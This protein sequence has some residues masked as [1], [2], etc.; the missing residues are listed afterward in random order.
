MEALKLRGYSP[1]RPVG[2]CLD[3]AASILESVNKHDPL[4]TV[5]RERIR[6]DECTIGR[7]E[8]GD[9]EMVDSWRTVGRVFPA[10]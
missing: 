3:S 6:N 1:E 8:N 9:S 2:I 7:I 5:H 4:V 10:I